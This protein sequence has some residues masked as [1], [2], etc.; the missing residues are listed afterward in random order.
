M[1][2]QQLTARGTSKNIVNQK[3]LDLNIYI[4]F[5]VVASVHDGAAVMNKHEESISLISQLCYNHAIHLC[6]FDS[7]HKSSM[8]FEVS[9]GGCSDSENEIHNSDD[10]LDISEEK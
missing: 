6:V 9:D 5:D 10:S 7:F 8:D 3:L 4:D 2:L 1:G